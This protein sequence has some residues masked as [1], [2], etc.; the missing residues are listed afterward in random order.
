MTHLLSAAPSDSLQSFGV[1]IQRAE[2]NLDSTGWKKMQHFLFLKWEWL[3]QAP[4]HHISKP[5]SR[6]GFDKRYGSAALTLNLWE[7][8]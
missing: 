7:V 8:V 5:I 1:L 3:L 2:V 4:G 6:H